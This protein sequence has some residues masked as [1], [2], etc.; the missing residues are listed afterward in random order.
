[1]LRP[2]LYFVLFNFYLCGASK[3]YKELWIN[4]AVSMDD[5]GH[6]RPITI[7]VILLEKLTQVTNN[8]LG[9]VHKNAAKRLANECSWSGI[10]IKWEDEKQTMVSRHNKLANRP[11]LTYHLQ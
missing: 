3:M 4:K 5:R 2:K 6:R 10:K 7:R 11:S 9:N 1:M 8:F